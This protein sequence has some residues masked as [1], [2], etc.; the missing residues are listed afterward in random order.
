MHSGPDGSDG[1]F[2]STRNFGVG[3]L[4]T[5]DQQDDI[6]IRVGEADQR[7][8]QW[9]PHRPGR[10]ISKDTVGL[11][12]PERLVRGLLSEPV[13]PDLLTTVL[14]DEIGGDPVQPRARIK[15]ARVVAAPFAKRRQ[16][17][18]SHQII[19]YLPADPASQIA[20]DMRSVTIEYKREPLGLRKRTRDHCRVGRHRLR[21]GPAHQ[22]MFPV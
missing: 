19:S 1:N 14:T 13:T 3:E 16:E 10:H 2:E 22:G 17:R 4:L 21:I 12:R 7:V 11:I 8:A 5:G 20:M 9:R 15:M 6:P 18:L